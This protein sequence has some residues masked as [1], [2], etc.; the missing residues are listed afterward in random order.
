MLRICT[1]KQIECFVSMERD[2]NF[3]AETS[4]H[5]TKYADILSQQE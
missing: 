2:I 1:G 5:N 3:T 4:L